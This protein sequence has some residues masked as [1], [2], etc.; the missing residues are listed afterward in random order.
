[1]PELPEVE[2]SRLGLLPHLVN[3]PVLDCVVRR[4]DLRLPMPQ[5]LAARLVGH[6]LSAI[7]R[8]GKYLLFHWPGANGW[9][10]LHLG[11][12]GSLRLVPPGTPAG[13]HDHVDLC[14]PATVLRLKDPRRFGLALW[15]EGE[16]PEQHPLLQSL[17][18]EPLS[19]TFTADELAALLA[20]R[21][22]PIKPLLM[23]ARLIVGVGNI[24]AAESLFRAHI[25][26]LRLAADLRIEE[27]R[28]LAAA[29][30][31][32]L[33]EAIAAGG[34]SVRD[35]V[36]SDGGAGSFQLRCAVYDR[37]GL[38]CLQCGAPIRQV[39]QAGRSSFYCPHCQT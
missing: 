20:R 28:K 17:G 27:I 8:R 34:S 1:M 11:M 21:K 39:R 37:A 3:E 15:I 29:I 10:M 12:S 5:D 16:H 6:R 33:Q 14:F 30:Q 2:V 9:L 26:P 23:N 38:P 32:T 19:A 36:H 35:Y 4:A 18:V 22:T 13:K 24:Y 31:E 7:V 25:S